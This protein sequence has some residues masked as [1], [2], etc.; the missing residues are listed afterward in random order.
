M[1]RGREALRLPPCRSHMPTSIGRSSQ[2][3]SGHP[4]LLG[5]A[6]HQSWPSLANSRRTMPSSVRERHRRRRKRIRLPIHAV[7]HRLSTHQCRWISRRRVPGD[8]TLLQHLL[9]KLPRNVAVLHRH[10]DQESAVP[11]RL[12]GRTR[13]RRHALQHLR[14]DVRIWRVRLRVDPAA[15]C[16]LNA[17]AREGDLACDGST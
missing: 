15:S 9:T 4:C 10:R 5:S 1:R 17:R 8:P 11:P 12:E 6:G 16:R 3:D 13:V 14:G 7:P 2:G